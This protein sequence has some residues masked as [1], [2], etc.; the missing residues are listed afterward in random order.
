MGAD[1]SASARVDDESVCDAQAEYT[2]TVVRNPGNPLFNA[3]RQD[4]VVTSVR[5]LPGGS[6]PGKFSR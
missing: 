2:A 4:L 6:W 5:A 3:S 1:L